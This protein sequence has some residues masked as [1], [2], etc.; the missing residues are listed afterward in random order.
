MNARLFRP[1]LTL[2]L[3]AL[4]FA[5]GCDPKLMGLESLGGTGTGTTGSGTPA[6]LTPEA[7]IIGNIVAFHTDLFHEALSVSAAFDSASVPLRSI[8]SGCA[9]L[10][11]LPGGPGIRYRLLFDG[12][13]DGHGTTYRGGG[14]L[15][16]VNNQDGYTFLPLFE[17]D[18]LRAINETDDNYNHT[19]LSPAT[20]AGS[21]EFAFER[22]QQG[23]VT[24]V[25]V[26][27]FLRH[28]VRG[29]T[30]TISYSDVA[31]TGAIGSH[32]LTP[33]TGSVARVVWDGVGLF[34]VEYAG[35]A[36]TYSMQGGRYSVNLSTGVVT[37]VT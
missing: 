6:T 31:Y 17:A 11:Q 37:V 8:E 10:A 4:A 22:D 24:R 19:V 7:L 21:F 29:D 13:V 3:A 12:C 25:H 15:M 20:T 35:G 5:M 23:V 30:V 34:D 28:G 18:L 2:T 26:N 16:V 1:V 36:A 14:D 32:P 27:Q 9:S 33:D